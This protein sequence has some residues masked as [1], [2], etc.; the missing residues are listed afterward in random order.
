[1]RPPARRGGYYRPRALAWKAAHLTA[2]WSVERPAP[3]WWAEHD[4]AWQIDQGILMSVSDLAKFFGWK[5]TRTYTLMRNALSDIATWEGAN[6]FRTISERLPNDERTKPEQS[7]QVQPEQEHD[8]PNDSR[9]V[10]EQKENASCARFSLLSLQTTTY[11]PTRG[12]GGEGGDPPWAGVH[13][14]DAPHPSETEPPFGVDVHGPSAPPHRTP[15]GAGGNA[16]PVV[17]QAPP[18]IIEPPREQPSPIAN[19]GAGGTGA[20]DLQSLLVKQGMPHGSA[21]TVMRLLIH[22]GISDVDAAKDSDEYDI[23]AIVG[24]WKT[25]TIRA[26]RAGGWMPPKERRALEMANKN[27]RPIASGR[28]KSF[29]DAL[30]AIPERDNNGNI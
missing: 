17:E 15:S 20:D 22:K 10:D 28:N 6:D 8:K 16:P 30:R 13:P 26:L 14:F 24:T 5:R 21:A 9:T 18:R 3:E 23:G 12:G 19:P 25:L 7:N 29:L 27:I 1:M 11:Q 4:V 2:D